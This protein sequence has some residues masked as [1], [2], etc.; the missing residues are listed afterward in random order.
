MSYEFE[1]SAITEFRLQITSM[2]VLSSANSLTSLM[3]F[4]YDFDVF[5][6]SSLR[7]SG[8]VDCRTSSHVKKKRSRGVSRDKSHAYSFDHHAKA[9]HMWYVDSGCS[10]HMTGYK[11]LLHNFVERPGGTVSFGNKTT[12]VIK[13]YGILSNGK[14]SIKKVLCVEGL[15]H[16]L[17]SASQFCDGYNIVLFSIINCL[18]INSDGVEIFE[19]RKFYNL[20]VVDFP[21]I[22]SSKPICLFSKATKGESWLWHRRFSHQ[23]F[24]D[25]SKLANGGLVKGLPKLTFERN[26]LCPACQMGKMKRSSHKSKTE[27]S[28]QSPLEMIRM[29]LCGPMRIQ[30]INGKKYIQLWLMNIH[31]IHG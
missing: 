19:G 28:Y 20:Y 16:N 31:G 25:I 24:S 23:N 8:S 27:S 14:V 21:V 18:I 6:R 15:S 3:F 13:G 4:E 9:R 17:F 29:D 12:G 10:R 1:Q 22:D 26:S 30:S 5:R 7:W 2:L 11:E